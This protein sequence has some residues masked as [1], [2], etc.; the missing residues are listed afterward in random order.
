MSD[1][2]YRFSEALWPDLT[3]SNTLEA[4]ERLARLLIQ[5]QGAAFEQVVRDDTG[6]ALTPSW[7]DAIAMAGDPR[8]DPAV[9]V[10]SV[11]HTSLG[12]PH[13]FDLAARHMMVYDLPVHF[14]ETVPLNSVRSRSASRQAATTKR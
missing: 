13:A 11:A 7:L 9:I 8:C 5:E 10:A 6:W 2:R 3:S 14:P 12:L 1:A 4:S